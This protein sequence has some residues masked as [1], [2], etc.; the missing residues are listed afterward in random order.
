MEASREQR[1][2]RMTDK[3]VEQR[4]E[5]ETPGSEGENR[6]Q[7]GLLIYCLEVWI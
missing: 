5:R 7:R 3:S 2:K 1:R 6:N 4:G